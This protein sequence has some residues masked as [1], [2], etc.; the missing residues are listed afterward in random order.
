MGVFVFSKR[1]GW[2][3]S[4]HYLLIVIA[5]RDGWVARLRFA[6]CARGRGSEGVNESGVPE[7][8]AKTR[9]I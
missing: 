6:R 4:P 9:P 7:Q 2:L 8:A 5:M 1:E 3:F